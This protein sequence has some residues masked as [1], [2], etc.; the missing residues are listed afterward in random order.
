MKDAKVYFRT[1]HINLAT[2]LHTLNFPID[3]IYAKDNSEIVEFYFEDTPELQ[4]V[5]DDFWNR[6]LKVEPHS[7]LI[8]RKELIDKIKYDKM[9]SQ[10]LSQR[11]PDD[12]I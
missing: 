11:P 2:T 6:R 4:R 10:K 9:G 3:G 7:L 8:T 1:Q 5:I 12:R